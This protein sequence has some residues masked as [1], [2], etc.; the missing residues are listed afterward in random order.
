MKRITG[1]AAVL[2]LLASI[3]AAH[4]DVSQYCD[5]NVGAYGDGLRGYHIITPSSDWATHNTGFSLD[6]DNWNT[7]SGPQWT[8]GLT[9]GYPDFYM[10]SHNLHSNTFWMRGD[11][12]QL[13][14]GRVVGRP[15]A[16]WQQV[17]IVAGT[18]SAPLDGLG[19]APCG[20]AE[21]TP[22]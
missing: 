19:A 16:G 21:N 17:G 6:L 7:Q 8:F 5:P 15:V 20:P 9:A 22:G 13:S 4:A 10:Q 14:L 18:S 1:L 3:P 11:T 12:G 2:G